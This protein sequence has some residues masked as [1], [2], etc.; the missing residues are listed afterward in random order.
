MEKNNHT[1][2]VKLIRGIAAVL[3]DR[4]HCHRNS[5]AYPQAPADTAPAQP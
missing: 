1:Y 3:K 2:G 5:L 4:M